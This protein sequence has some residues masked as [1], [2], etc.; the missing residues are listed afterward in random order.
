MKNLISFLVCFCALGLSAQTRSGQLNDSFSWTL[1]DSVLTIHGTGKM[2]SY[3]PTSIDKLP[4]QDERFAAEVAKI[5]ISEGITEVGAYNFGSR[6][7]VRNV[8]NAKEHTFYST[9][10]ATTTELFYN[11]KEVSLPSTLKKIGHHAF[12]R[13]PLSHVALPEGLVEIAAGAFTNT[14]LQCVILPSTIRKVGPE[15]FCGCQNLRAIDFANASIK[16]AEGVLFDAEHLRL[17]MHTSKIKSVAA[18]AFNSTALDGVAEETLLEMF[19]TDGPQYFIDTYVPKRSNF[20]GSEE[21][22][23]HMQQGALDLFYEKEAKNATSLFELDRFCLQPYDAESGTCRIITVNNGT[24]LLSLTPEQAAS[25]AENWEAVRKSAK[26]VYKPVNGRVELQSVN[27]NI[28]GRTVV[29]A[30]L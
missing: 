3:N 12:A 24:L 1:A 25:A 13:M 9:Q 11:I 21:E 28:D 8:R 16:L 15:A 4:W 30:L 26:P 2:P 17:L 6:A 22:Y 19:R 18:T 27:Y 10:G 29:A 5:V 23:N 20:G 14:A 7:Y